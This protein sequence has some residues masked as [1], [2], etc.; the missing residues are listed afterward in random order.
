MT[1]LTFRSGS[2]LDRGFMTF[3]CSKMEIKLIENPTN[4]QVTYSKG[5][6]GVFK[7]THELS[8]LY[9]TKLSVSKD[10]NRQRESNFCSDDVYHHAVVK[11]K[12]VLLVIAIQI[13][14]YVVT[15]MSIGVILPIGLQMSS[16]DS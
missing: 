2:N 9:D 7:K 13:G 1:L 8:A 5:G 4:M 15:M 3:G 11:V 12:A 6:N 10:C 16:G 14:S